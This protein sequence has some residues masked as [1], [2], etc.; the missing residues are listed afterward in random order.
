MVSKSLNQKGCRSH[1]FLT[2]VTV[3]MGEQTPLRIQW[4]I[5]FLFSGKRLHT[6]MHNFMYNFR[7]FMYPSLRLSV[8]IWALIRHGFECD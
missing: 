8:C 4:K 1:W 5:L 6:H 7:G 3:G 2:L